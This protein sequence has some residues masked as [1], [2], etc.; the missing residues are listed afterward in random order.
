MGQT[1]KLLKYSQLPNLIQSSPEIKK[2]KENKG[3]LYI[4]FKNHDI[5][6]GNVLQEYKEGTY[7][8]H[9]SSI[10]FQGKMFNN[11]CQIGETF[12][13]N[14]VCFQGLTTNE[15]IRYGIMIHN[16]DCVL[17]G[18]FS[19]DGKLLKGFFQPF[20]L[21]IIATI[22]DKD[23]NQQFIKM[24]FKTKEIIYTKQL[25]S[26]EESI[27]KQLNILNITPIFYQIEEPCMKIN[28]NYFTKLIEGDFKNIIEEPL[29]NFDYVL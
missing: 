16:N 26:N 6:Q 29:I 19:T 14:G 9:H 1:N 2:I 4:K 12:F 8:Y 23:G 10:R 15:G 13:K 20:I 21:V 7:I 18:K 27:C 28:V 5:F 22:T 11:G 3:K 17:Q 25:N 24:D